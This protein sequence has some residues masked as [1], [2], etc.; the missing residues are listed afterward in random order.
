MSRFLSLGNPIGS[1]AERELQRLKD[2]GLEPLEAVERVTATWLCTQEDLRSMSDG[3]ALTYL[4]ASELFRCRPQDGRI[5]FTKAGKQDLR[6]R[7]PSGEARREVGELL[8]FKLG[9][10]FVNVH[11]TLQQ[12]AER[13]KEIA[14]IFSQPFPT[15]ST[16]P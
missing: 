6:Y 9:A 1:L 15:T 16:T 5:S 7:R 10:F 8:R 12:D 3:R 13:E 14:H 2:K 11:R 4:L